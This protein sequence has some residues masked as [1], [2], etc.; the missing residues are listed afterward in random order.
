M[1]TNLK[2]SLIAAAVAATFGA[3]AFAAPAGPAINELTTT[4]SKQGTSAT[5]SITT[6]DVEFTLGAE[7]SEGDVL[8]LTLTDG[9]LASSFSAFPAS[10]TTGV[11]GQSV[12]F[13]RLG[14]DSTSITYRVTNVDN[15]N[16]NGTTG[17]VVEFGAGVNVN[18]ASIAA[19]NAGESIDLNAAATTGS[20]G[21]AIVFDTD[22]EELAK[23][24]DQINDITVNGATAFDG[25]ID[26]T[27]MREVFTGAGTNNTVTEDTLV[28]SH[29]QKDAAFGT[30][31]NL[32]T[33]GNVT[34]VLKGD[35]T[36]LAAGQFSAP[37]A[38]STSMNLAD[39]ELTLVYPNTFTTDTIT[40]TSN[41]A[42]SG[43][44]LVN[45]NFTLD[46]SQSYTVPGNALV[47]SEAMGTDVAAGEWTLNGADINIPY[48]PYDNLDLAANERAL[49]QI[50]YVTNHG[51]QAGSIYVTAT[52][53]DGT[54]VLNNVEIDQITGG[55]MRS[56]AGLIRAELISEGFYDGKLSIDVTV[57][58]ADEDITVYA[59]Y[60]HNTETDRGVVITDQYKGKTSVQP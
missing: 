44:T 2:A 59:A 16:N 1:K 5:A 18:G 43:V 57:N 6:D 11:L 56:I 55:Q 47:Y 15:A 48:M 45:Q 42:G 46:A 33:E 23:V 19:L 54:V 34:L 12:T 51:T 41:G 29:A 7:Y 25:E 36:G 20:G 22:S 52:A 8:V 3:N 38:S 40:F 37:G 26:V 10:I 4:Y 49:G 32:V 39:S 13:G 30:W 28:V 35:F 53:E 17:L 50:I 9:G 27:M 21:V 58:A 24:E 31:E 60:K 14:N